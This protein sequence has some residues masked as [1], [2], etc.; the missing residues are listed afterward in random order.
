MKKLQFG[1]IVADFIIK[2][3]RLIEKVFLFLLIISVFCIPFVHTNYDLS[4]YLPAQTQTK[5]GI[6]LMEHE[7]GYPGSARVMIDDISIYEAKNYVDQIEKIDGVDSVT[8]A[9][10][11]GQVDVSK[12][13]VAMQDLG[14]YYK[15][16]HALL[17]ISFDKGD[18][19]PET[20]KA[21]DKI[22][23]LI[24]NKGH[25][26]GPAVDN[27]N[28]GDSING[29]MPK[30]T[31]G[32]VVLIIA[33]LILTTT[34]WFEPILFMLTMGVAI[35]LNIGSNL[36]F[37]E[38][39]FITFS[40]SSILQLAV[41]MDYS[42][43]LIHAFSSEKAK[44]LG[45]EKTMSNAL[46]KIL[47]SIVSSAMTATIGF[48][49]L[50]LMKFSIGKDMGLVLAKGM[51]WSL[52]SITLLMPVLIIRWE[53]L[54]EK[55]KHK[56][57]VPNLDGVAKKIFGI[58]KF[59]AVIT[60]IVIVPA[61]FAQ[62]MN[63]FKY[64]TASMGGGK[65]S[66]VYADQ[67]AIKAIFGQSN[68][69]L[70]M[71][72]NENQVKEKQLSEELKNLNFV[73]SVTSL[74]DMLPG[75]IPESILPGSLTSKLHSAQYVRLI[76][77]MNFSPENDFAFKSV[78]TIKTITK[79]YYPENTYYLGD[80]PATKDMKDVILSDYGIVEAISILGV[81]AVVLFSFRSLVLTLAMLISIEIAITLNMAIP[82]LFGNDLAFLGYLMVSSIQ[83]GSTIDY[84]ILMTNNYLHE[85]GLKKTPPQAAIGAIKSS[86]VS[87]MTSG[88]VLT[89]V[90]F[91]LYFFIS[92][93][94][95]GD[96]GRLIGLGTLISM[97][98]VICLLPFLLVIS[99]PL[100]TKENVLISKIT[101][102]IQK[103][104]AKKYYA[105]TKLLVNRIA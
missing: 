52:L 93:S 5:Q 61:Y 90:G 84:A 19:D 69:M 56:S 96:M 21:L 41:A 15:D 22:Y 71:V 54:I 10:S 12:D 24:G 44:G 51:V 87:I 37:G 32:V 16:N 75:G 66:K 47:P 45:V 76:V 85:R 40:V 25:Y 103:L 101:I 67:Q 28:T 97:F 94:A 63:N 27:K 31:A 100:R 92:I 57:F 14:D 88:T 83:L 3:Q 46:K 98:F 7:F 1:E 26:A 95:I 2:K 20:N 82:F 34:S 72:P 35:I 80:T 48:L 74:A 86:M 36:I 89:V 77:D 102:Y 70:L 53:K 78:E 11:V 8:W 18:S 105:T 104:V 81:A 59:V 38:I 50:A 64:G 65:G 6:K 79:K 13:Y 4:K 42:V 49:V 62:S 29:I 30:V 23:S 55:T 9:G 60:L 99:E 33:V 91:G 43:F 68:T 39:S 17:N 58:G 73:R